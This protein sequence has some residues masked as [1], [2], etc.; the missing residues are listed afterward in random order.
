IGLFLSQHQGLGFRRGVPAQLSAR[1]RPTRDIARENEYDGKDELD[2]EPVAANQASPANSAQPTRVRVRPTVRPGAQVAPADTDSNT[3]RADQN[4]TES[5]TVD[6]SPAAE[7]ATTPPATEHTPTQ[8]F[9]GVR[10]ARPQHHETDRP[11]DT[12]SVARASTAS[13]E[14]SAGTEGSASES[15]ADDVKGND[16]NDASPEQTSPG[17]ADV[18]GDDIVSSVTVRE[19]RTDNAPG[20]STEKATPLAE[21]KNEPVSSADAFMH[22][23]VALANLRLRRINRSVHKDT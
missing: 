19:S 23:D 21:D 5:G 13:D 17:A 22:H 6:E 10:F 20:D 3:D 11:S 12:E 1:Q 14:A 2:E 7:S 16:E 4:D 8:S 18:G 9:R 15:I